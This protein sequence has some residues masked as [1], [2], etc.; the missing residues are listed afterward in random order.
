MQEGLASTANSNTDKL[1]SCKANSSTDM[2]DTFTT[3]SRTGE[4]TLDF[5]T[6]GQ[7]A[8]TADSNTDKMVFWLFLFRAHAS[9]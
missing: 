8:S 4:L 2:L 7:D 9:R 1:D 5:S 6:N 3:N